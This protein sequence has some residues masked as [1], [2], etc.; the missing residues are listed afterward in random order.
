MQNLYVNWLMELLVHSRSRSNIV[1][2]LGVNNDQKCAWKVYDINPL[3]V[4]DIGSEDAWRQ[5]GTKSPA[6][7]KL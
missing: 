2:I 3:D 5:I 7:T 6:T 1:G 4:G